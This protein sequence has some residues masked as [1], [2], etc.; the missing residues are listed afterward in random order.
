MTTPF[1]L[2]RPR[3]RR[4]LALAVLLLPL[5]AAA[6]P[7]A[8]QS[9]SF[10]NQRDDQYRLLGLK[11]AKEAYEAARADFDR[12]RQLAEGGLISQTDLERARSAFADAEVN[13]QQS[14]LAVLFERQFVSVAEAVKRRDDD[15]AMRVRLRLANTSGGGAEFRKLLNLDD[16]LFRSLQ[17]DV[18]ND[19]YVSLLNDEGAVISRPYEAKIEELRFGQ[20]Q[21]VDFALL[22][23]LDAVTVS[24]IYGNG[25]TRSLKIQ[26]QKDAGAN[27][28]SVQSQQFS[29]EAELGG[30]AT[31]DLTLELFSDAANTFG[32]EV[33][34]LPAQIG[35]SFRDPANGAR[36][37][38]I[39]FTASA[40][41]QRAA[42]EV[43]LPDRPTAAVP[44]DS[45]RVFYAV[46]VPRRAGPAAGG[47]EDGAALFPAAAAIAAAGPGRVWSESEV[48]ALGAGYVRLELVPRGKGRLLVRAPL[49][50]HSVAR[51]EAAA[52][53]L[54]VLNEGTRRLDNV[55]VK[56]DAPLG[57]TAAA[58]PELLPGL[59]VGQESAIR[60]TVTPARDAAPGRYEVRV[61]TT[62]LS[63][64]QPVTAEDKTLTVEV[65]PGSHLAATV[66][67]V[68]LIVGL[69]G[70]VVAFGVRLSRR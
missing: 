28:V 36:L 6:P 5:L 68:L 50:Y 31:F 53:E 41:I 22:Q 7:A 64:N 42:L 32:L 70:G 21:A 60:V 49:L 47:G 26:L 43:S 20:P 39:R 62:A 23:D 17:P 45:A 67:L 11:R 54:Q 55:A 1:A 12:R 35:R 46:A 69:V 61:R 13:Y 9:G 2:R 8:A 24:L 30:T 25:S 56:L 57:W 16:E 29:Q 48:A 33:L 37:S 66:A 44:M 52:V 14:L 10:F 59:E 3:A 4:A 34:N 38:Q 63:N 27:R 15:G 58:A 65:R 40:N 51:R 19:V 18:V